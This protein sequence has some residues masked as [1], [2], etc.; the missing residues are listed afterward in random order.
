MQSKSGKIQGGVKGRI[1]VW[2]KRK[3]K[4]KMHVLLF[5]GVGGRVCMSARVPLPSPGKRRNWCPGCPATARDGKWLHVSNPLHWANAA[6]SCEAA[7]LPGC[8]LEHLSSCTA[9]VPASGDGFDASREPCFQIFQFLLSQ[10]PSSPC[11]EDWPPPLVPVLSSI[12][13]PQ[14]NSGQKGAAGAS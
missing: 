8:K 6:F 1:I 7:Q 2:K 3:S 14:S 13:S 12:G 9:W 11:W 4:T 5:N 10:G